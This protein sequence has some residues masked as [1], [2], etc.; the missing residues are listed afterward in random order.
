MQLNG[1]RKKPRCLTMKSKFETVFCKC[2]EM[3]PKYH[4][5]ENK[6]LLK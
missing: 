4:E 1:P 6:L 5:D 3:F 2:A